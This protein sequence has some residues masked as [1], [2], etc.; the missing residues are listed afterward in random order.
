[1]FQNSSEFPIL[2][3]FSRKEGLFADCSWLLGS[4]QA[5]RGACCAAACPCPHAGK[6]RQIH[7]SDVPGGGRAR[8]PLVLAGT[9]RLSANAGV[10]QTLLPPC[11]KHSRG[12]LPPPEEIAASD[13]KFSKQSPHLFS[14]L[15]GHSG[16]AGHPDR[17][18]PSLKALQ[19]GAVLWEAVCCRAPGPLHVG[20]S[21]AR[22]SQEQRSRQL[23]PLPSKEDIQAWLGHL[24]TAQREQ[25]IQQAACSEAH[26]GLLGKKR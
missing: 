25:L 4:W 17:L 3:H 2:A 26:M 24:Q 21:A 7:H 13:G 12:R 8:A 5:V 19:D 23:A 11:R 14:R 16:A 18:T 20:L 15:R 22:G 10:P 9:G 6:W 1:M